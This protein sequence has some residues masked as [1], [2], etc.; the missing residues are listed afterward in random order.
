MRL[1][2]KVKSVLIQVVQSIT[3]LLGDVMYGKMKK[4]KTS[5]KR[6][7]KGTRY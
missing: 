3:K 2:L 4:K 6:K 1:H 7:K 5:S